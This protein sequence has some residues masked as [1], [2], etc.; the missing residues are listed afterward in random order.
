[1]GLLGVL[2]LLVPS[3]LREA[4]FAHYLLDGDTPW[5]LEVDIAR[6]LVAL[7]AARL[8][9]AAATTRL[10]TRLAARAADPAH[11]CGV[12]L[13]EE[14]WTTLCGAFLLAFS[15]RVLTRHN[16]GCGLGGTATCL[17]GWPHRPDSAARHYLAAETAT[18]LLF[19]LK[20][21][22]RLGPPDGRD[23][24]LHHC[25]T[26]ALIVV[27]T[28]MGLSRMGVLVLSL[29]SFSNPFLHLAKAINQLEV[30]RARAPA[31]AFAAFA[32]VFFAS[33]VLA[34]PALVLK[35]ALLDSRRNLPP[36]ALARFGYLYWGINSL[37]WAI[38][39]LQ[40][41]W[42]RAIA[43]V[44]SAA[45]ASPEA[46]SR[47]SKQL[48]PSR[49]YGGATPATPEC[50][51]LPGGG[52]APDASPPPSVGTPSPVR[53]RSGRAARESARAS[54]AAHPLQRL[55]AGSAYSGG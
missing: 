27:S 54:P 22:L 34:V 26:L 48:D 6:W 18:Y 31:V 53:V 46:A 39:L 23:M 3:Q 41:V 7:L 37:L 19:L 12:K 4:N 14:A 35:P 9:F 52:A 16:G 5:Q 43:R 30:A 25:A 38:Y 11:R 2:P 49:R 13:R 1:M 17:A 32:A 10:A 24:V 42:L 55:S 47:V 33:R 40:L 44:L 29:Y 50:S 8:L 36:A 21:V 28:A 51:A 15:L 20:P 45:A